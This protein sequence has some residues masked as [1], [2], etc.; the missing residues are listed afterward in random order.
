MEQLRPVVKTPV[1]NPLPAHQPVLTPRAAL[2]EDNHTVT[3]PL[4]GTVVEIMVKA[5]QKV[6]AGQVLLIIEAMKMENEI[7]APAGGVVRE[8]MVQDGA[9]VVASQPL[10]VLG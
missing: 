9:S 2:P 8:V 1:K 3:S 10:I 5:G 4:P 6:R 7:T